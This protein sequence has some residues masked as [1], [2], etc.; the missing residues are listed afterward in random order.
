MARANDY[1]WDF[2]KEGKTYQYKEWPLLAMVTILEDNSTKDEYRFKLR[3][4]KSNLNEEYT[5]LEFIVTSSKDDKGYYN[6]MMQFYENEEYFCN[7][8][9]ERKE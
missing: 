1:G 7:Y 3:V 2:V 8:K 4:E 9:W 6:N 5:P